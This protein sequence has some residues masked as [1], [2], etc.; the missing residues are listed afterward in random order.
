M[1]ILL[2]L[3]LLLLAVSLVDCI[4]TELYFKPKWRA[5]GANAKLW[6][7]LYH[8][9][10][11][12]MFVIWYWCIYLIDCN[13]LLP[14]AILHSCGWEDMLYAV[15]VPLF[16]KAKEAWKYEP[17]LQIG[18][19]IFPYEWPWLGDYGGFWKFLSYNIMTLIGGKRVQLLGLVISMIIGMFIVILIWG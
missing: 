9:R 10:T 12:V 18:P 8:I 7:N 14:S 16:A 2:E 6:D 11:V 3:L 4:T 15:W 13:L 1:N 17:G 5:P 19:W